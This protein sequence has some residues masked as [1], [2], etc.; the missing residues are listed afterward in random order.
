MPSYHDV[1]TPEQ[2]EEMEQDEPSQPDQLKVDNELSVH[3]V[4]L[5]QGELIIKEAKKGNQQAIAMLEKINK[6]AASCTRTAETKS[7]TN[8]PAESA[9]PTGKA[10]GKSAKGKDHAKAHAKAEP[11]DKAE[12]KAKARKVSFADAKDDL[13]DHDA[14][15]SLKSKTN[16][17]I[18]NWAAKRK[19]I[20]E[21][22]FANAALQKHNDDLIQLV[23][24]MNKHFECLE[25]ES[26]GIRCAK[27]RSKGWK[28]K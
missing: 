23:A 6:V 11:K 4:F 26:T 13:D 17:P 15:A 28:A 3:P 5:R 18:S 16:T 24:N 22:E 27:H 8:P 12:P 25:L 19:T 20:T 14:E 1:P 21:L 7:K 2:D 10:Q 9:D